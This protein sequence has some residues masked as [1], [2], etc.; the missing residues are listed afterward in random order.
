MFQK[1]KQLSYK[2]L[3]KSEKYM[4]TDMIY[5]AKGGFWLSF[6]QVLVSLIGLGVAIAFAN[7]L[8]KETYG[9]YKFAISIIS[10]LS[11]AALPGLNGALIQAISR[12]YEGA[13][14]KSVITKIKFGLI[15]TL[16]S[17]GISAY[18]YLNGNNTLTLIFI[19]SALFIPLLNS[20]QIWLDL[21]NGRKKFKA[22]SLNQIFTK[23]FIGLSLVIT[24]FLSKNIF[25][26]ILVF[27]LS[28][29]IAHLII[30][31]YLLIKLPVNQNDDGDTINYGK[32]LTLMEI[33]TQISINLDKILIFHFLGSMEV[34][35]YSIAKDP[36]QQIKMPL[37]NM[38]RLLLPK[39]SIKPIHELK[40]NLWPKI[41]KAHLMLIPGIIAYIL[42]A[43]FIF[44]L[45][46]PLYTE[47]IIFSQILILSIFFFPQT[48]FNNILGAHK[49]I[50]E[51]Y[52]AKYFSAS[53]KIILLI[54]LTPLF[55]IWGVVFTFLVS[56]LFSY[57]FLAV[58]FKKVV[59]N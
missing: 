35:I 38:S 37:N 28:N 6:G 34:A 55:G 1:L 14:R 56:E 42:I 49:K 10:L 8:P 15:G 50:R 48:V 23:L 25:I 45:I 16:T 32:H 2:L 57:I 41:F 26:L 20:F 17:L 4:K 53:F 44:K 11:I 39:L 13:Y 52:L 7:L 40:Q 31:L 30:Y 18:Y 46:F 22:L 3:K 29:I 12:G 9:T 21:L 59:K 43:P 24:I 58:I 19:I 47:S 36:I 5:L 54:V 51:L 27:F 33:L